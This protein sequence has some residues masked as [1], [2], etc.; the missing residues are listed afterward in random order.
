MTLEGGTLEFAKH[1]LHW[2]APFEGIVGSKR[3]EEPKLP[4]EIS[5]AGVRAPDYPT[6]EVRDT[7]T[8]TVAAILHGADPKEPK[9]VRVLARV[10]N[11][12]TDGSNTSVEF[13]Q[14][15]ADSDQQCVDVGPII[16][17]AADG[18]INRHANCRI[19]A[20]FNATRT[21]RVKWADWPD[22]VQKGASVVF[23]ADLDQITGK[24][25]L[26]DYQ[27]SVAMTGRY[28]DCFE[29]HDLPDLKTQANQFGQYLPRPDA[30]VCNSMWTPSG[31]AGAKKKK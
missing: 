17:I 5:E 12:H 21:F 11:I 7:K 15:G 23:Y 30:A 31:D 27:V 13:V 26:S 6:A 25:S 18:T 24:G 4:E 1:A 28:V 22:G 10:T 8:E 19:T 2:P 16:G 20:T 9:L 29:N 3:T 14:I